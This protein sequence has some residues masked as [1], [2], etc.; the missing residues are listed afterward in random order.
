[1]NAWLQFKAIVSVGS[2]DYPG[3]EV[4]VLDATLNADC[5]LITI[6]TEITTIS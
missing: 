3:P 5:V 1:M 4:L 2:V 6:T